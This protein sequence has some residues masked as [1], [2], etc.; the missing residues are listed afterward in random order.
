MK[1]NP[2]LEQQILAYRE[3]HADAELRAAY[4]LSVGSAPGKSWKDF[5]VEQALSEEKEG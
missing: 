5:I 4:R 1:L 3:R 2:W